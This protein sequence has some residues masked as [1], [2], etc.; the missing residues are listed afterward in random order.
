[1]VLLTHQ[2]HL[3]F[4]VRLDGIELGFEFGPEARP[5]GHGFQVAVVEQF[6]EQDGMASQVLRG[7]ARCTDQIDHPAQR[8]RILLQ[9]CEIGAATADPFEQ[10]EAA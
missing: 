8:L 10:V 9:E 6:V 7:P 4:H 3:T 5:V 2:V 1:M